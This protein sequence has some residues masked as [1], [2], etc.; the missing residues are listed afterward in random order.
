MNKPMLIIIIVFVVTIMIIGII[1]ALVMLS[2][3]REGIAINS[4]TFTTSDDIGLTFGVQAGIGSGITNVSNNTW[5]A[6]PGRANGNSRVDY[7]FTAANLDAMTVSSTNAEGNILL[8]FA[9]GDLE[10][11]F[12]IT[13]EFHEN[14]DMSVFEPGRIRL[15]LVFENARNIDTVI[16]W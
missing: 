15:R 3:G 10:K 5:R 14:V 2:F 7:T 16:N 11:T 12:D 9:Q 1:T 4:G 13:G 6:T 8:T